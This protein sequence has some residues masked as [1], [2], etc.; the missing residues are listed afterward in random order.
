ME[1]KIV[2]S[3]LTHYSDGHFVEINLKAI[4]KG[5]YSYSEEICCLFPET[6]NI[7]VDSFFLCT[8]PT[9]FFFFLSI[10]SQTIK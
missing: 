2:L 7:F 5:F 3:N 9:G 4:F 8:F 6:N 10:L 1:L